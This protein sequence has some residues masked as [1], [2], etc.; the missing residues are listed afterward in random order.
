MAGFDEDGEQELN[1]AARAI[2]L[3]TFGGTFYGGA[4][5]LKEFLV[6]AVLLDRPRPAKTPAS[7][8]CARRCSLACVVGF[9]IAIPECGQVRQ[10]VTS[11][12]P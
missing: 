10:P 12:V 5:G 11:K 4:P 9:A 1:D 6:P 2:P 3:A 7:M 8:N